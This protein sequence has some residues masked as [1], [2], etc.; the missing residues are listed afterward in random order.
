MSRRLLWSLRVFHIALAVLLLAGVCSAAARQ[1]DR[2]DLARLCNAAIVAAAL[3]AGAARVW[4]WA[5]QRAIRRADFSVGPGD[6]G[7]DSLRDRR[8]LVR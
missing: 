4:Q 3:T 2:V 7:I 1:Y 5:A 6:Y 8:F